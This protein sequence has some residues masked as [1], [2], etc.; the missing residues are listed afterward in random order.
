MTHKN[1]GNTLN[2]LAKD[3]REAHSYTGKGGV[4]VIYINEV[5]GWVNELRDPQDWQPGC[6]A[7]TEDGACYEATGGNSH[8]G[9]ERWEP[10]NPAS[11]YLAIPSV[12]SHWEGQGGIY[13]GIIRD[14]ATGNQWH[15][16]LAQDTGIETE[17]SEDY[18]E[19]DGEFSDNDGLHNTR[20]ILAADPNNTAANY[21][22]N[23]LIDG[24][25]DFYWLAPAELNLVRANL[26]DHCEPVAH[27]SSKQFSSDSAWYQHF[28]YGHQ[29]IN[30]KDE[31]LAVRA[32]R[33]LPIQ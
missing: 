23:L 13:A 27:W 12:G 19:I 6:I 25:Q 26:R 9:A 20:L 3:W 33:R 29:R 32:V 18:N 24:H 4:I 21:C 7:I 30:C 2:R 11:E 31:V 17:W 28:A 15:L 22:A 14:P 1:P 10:Y 16:I 5:Q 8:N